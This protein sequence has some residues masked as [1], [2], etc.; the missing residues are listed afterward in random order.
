M[1]TGHTPRSHADY[2]A[3]FNARSL[4]VVMVETPEAI[5]E[6]ESAIALVVDASEQLL[7]NKKLHKL[8]RFILTAGNYMN[9]GQRTGDAPGPQ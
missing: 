6:V 5:A 9:A 3:M 2:A 8:F 4:A 7:T 1:H